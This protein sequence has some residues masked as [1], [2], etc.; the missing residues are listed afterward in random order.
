MFSLSTILFVSCSLGGSDDPFGT[1]YFLGHVLDSAGA[2]VALADLRR[3]ELRYVGGELCV[4]YWN[5]LDPA[6]R[7]ELRPCPEVLL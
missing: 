4:F 7:K 1:E 2:A 3:T 5:C 6:L